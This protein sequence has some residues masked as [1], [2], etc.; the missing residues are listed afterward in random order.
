MEYD[1]I[2]LT[3]SECDFLI[4]CLK[5]YEKELGMDVTLLIDKIEKHKQISTK[6][7]GVVESVFFEEC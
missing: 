2:K 6:Q 7:K 3:S 1:D 4:W 5:P